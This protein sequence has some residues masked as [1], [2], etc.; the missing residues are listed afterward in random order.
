MRETVNLTGMV[1]RSSHSGE[2]ERRLVNLTRER[3]KITAFARGARRPGSALMAP[4]RTFAFGVFRLY[5]GRDAYSLQSAEIS[6]YF[7]EIAMDMEAACYGSYFLELADYYSRENLDGTEQ[8]KLIY[9]SLR[10]LLKPA[11]P[12]R[13]V[14]RI[15]ELKTMVI[16]GEYTENP[17]WKVSEAAAYAWAYVAATPTEGLYRFTLKEEVLQEFSACVE[18]NMRRYIDRQFHS[19]DILAVL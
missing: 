3:G 16:N 17:P 19:L 13:L 15:Y 11:I 12:N 7:E 14:R 5:E 18:E 4:G 8:L 6:N 10:A 2:A 1:T 9:Q